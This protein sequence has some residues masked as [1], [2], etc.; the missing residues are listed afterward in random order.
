MY[1]LECTKTKTKYNDEY[2]NKEIDMEII[3]YKK[4]SSVFILRF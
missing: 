1:K 3:K 2:I 4:K